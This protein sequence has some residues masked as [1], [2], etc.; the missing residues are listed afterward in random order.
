MLSRSTEKEIRFYRALRCQI[1][2]SQRKQVINS[3]NTG[4]LS[5]CEE[6]AFI[7]IPVARGGSLH[8]ENRKGPM[9]ASQPGTFLMLV[10][11]AAAQPVHLYP[12]EKKCEAEWETTV[13]L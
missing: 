9:S 2:K 8:M 7:S 11:T 4:L 10:L 3:L 5:P 6:S 1:E 12:I 13:P